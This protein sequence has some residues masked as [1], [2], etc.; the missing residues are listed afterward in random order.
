M[1]NYQNEEGEILVPD[2]LKNYLGG[3]EKI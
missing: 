2:V 1:E 3:M